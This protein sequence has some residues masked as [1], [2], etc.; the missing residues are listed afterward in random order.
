MA[1][2]HPFKCPLAVLGGGGGMGGRHVVGMQYRACVEYEGASLRGQLPAA[3]LAQGKLEQNVK[4]TEV[5]DWC[6]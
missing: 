2:D 6:N 1:P 5:H 4:L 3:M